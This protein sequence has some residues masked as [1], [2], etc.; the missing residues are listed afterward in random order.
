[1]RA[2]HRRPP[3]LAHRHHQGDN[4]RDSGRPDSP[5][6]RAR[7]ARPPSWPARGRAADGR[8]RL[9]RPAFL[10]DRVRSRDRPPRVHRAAPRRR[11]GVTVPGR[12]RRAG[13]PVRPARPDRR[14]VHLVAP[15][16][17]RPQPLL[18]L[19]GGSG[20]VPLMSMIRAH[21][22][23][24]S[25]VPVGLIYSVRSPSDVIYA[26]ELSQRTLFRPSPSI[27]S[28]PGRPARARARAA[29]T[30]PRSPGW[31]RPPPPSPRSSSAAPPA[32][33]RPPRPSWSTPATPPPP[34]KPSASAP[35]APKARAPARPLRRHLSPRRP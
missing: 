26:S 7:L 31:P 3:A 32:S 9:L 29:S 16:S 35:P 27:T 33:S 8:G 13:R 4:R 30:P 22:A 20:V 15:E 6:G 34:S 12:D 24:R 21:G 5:A 25:Q 23:A 1:M 19:A 2:T 10:L 11:R 18:L 28:T 14:L 17:A